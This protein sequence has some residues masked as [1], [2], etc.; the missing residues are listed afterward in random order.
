MGILPAAAGSFVEWYDFAI[1]SYISS[2]VT[3]NFFADGRGG[4]ISTWAGFAITIFFR[5]FGGLLFGILSDRLGRKLAMQVTIALMLAST[6]AQGCLPS[7]LSS[8]EAWGWF[9]LV[10]LLICRAVQG[11]SAGGELS[12]AMVYISEIS[13]RETLGFNLSWISVSGGFG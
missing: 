1:Y 8:G 12:A 2:Y 7:F 5:P 10:A 13:P 9:G 3:A 4:S 11:L 6:V